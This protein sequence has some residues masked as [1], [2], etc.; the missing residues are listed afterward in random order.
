M[1]LA[2]VV[3]KYEPAAVQFIQSEFC[4]C[5]IWIMSCGGLHLRDLTHSILTIKYRSPEYRNDHTNR[6]ARRMHTSYIM[7]RLLV[8]VE[9]CLFSLHVQCFLDIAGRDTV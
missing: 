6:K 9:Q 4:P 1:S 5:T 3:V 2:I 7:R 8:L